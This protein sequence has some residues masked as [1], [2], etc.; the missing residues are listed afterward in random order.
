MLDITA[1]VVISVWQQYVLS[2]GI[3]TSKVALDIL[4]LNF[5]TAEKI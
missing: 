1:E 3:D 4:S 2:D 5:K